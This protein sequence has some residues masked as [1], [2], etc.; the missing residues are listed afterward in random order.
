VQNVIIAAHAVRAAIHLHHERARQAGAAGDLQLVEAHTG[1]RAG[2]DLD[3]QRAVAVLHE[4]AVH[5]QNAD[6]ATGKHHAIV[7]DIAINRAVPA[8][9]AA[10]LNR[11]IAG[12][13]SVWVSRITDLECTALDGGSAGK[14]VATQQ[15]GC[16]SPGGQARCA[17]DIV[18]RAAGRGNAVRRGQRAVLDRATG[19]INRVDILRQITKVECATRLDISLAGLAECVS[20]TC[21]QRAAC[22]HGRARVGIYAGE[23]DGAGAGAFLRQGASP[24]RNASIGRITCRVENQGTVIGDISQENAAGCVDDGAIVRED[25]ARLVGEGAV[26]REDAARLVGEGAARLV[27]DGAVVAEAPPVSLVKVPS[28]KR[29]PP[30]SIVPPLKEPLA[31]VPGMVAVT[32]GPTSTCP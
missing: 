9:R 32:P 10:A 5:C 16:A 23:G 22:N 11:Y 28:S 8:Q 2:R 20:S 29:M 13:D 24:G 1:H 18:N 12:E 31:K 19:K 4:I 15:R 25:A 17:S 27:V 3:V 7:D 21:R 26:V 30:E 14:A 6:G